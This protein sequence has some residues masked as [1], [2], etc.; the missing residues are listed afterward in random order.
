M[1]TTTL[2]DPYAIFAFICAT[3]LPIIANDILGSYMAYNY[4]Y[5]PSVI[6]RLAINLYLYLVP[7]TTN[8]G[9]YLYATIN[10]AIPF[11]IYMLL[12]KYLNITDDNRNDR[13]K[14]KRIS[15][16]YITIPTIIA[17]VVTV[18]L[19][20]GVF[21][22]QM[23]AIASN[24]MVPV[25]ER[26]DALIFDKSEKGNIKIGDVIAFRHDDKIVTHRVVK[27]KENSNMR[28]F[29]T[30]GDANPSNDANPTTEDE[31]LG[32]VKIITKYIGY[33]TVWINELF[34]GEIYK[35]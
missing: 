4:G 15:L 23:I 18:I 24:S 5:L 32:V 29:Y 12:G 1:E 35:N 6:Y 17:L 25:F 13:K 10:V 31:I 34:G 22:Y 11:T 3:V 21:R 27:I 20:S 33:P 2:N 30:K 16:K 19:V 8:L 14:E 26:G 7:I 9:D 28:Y